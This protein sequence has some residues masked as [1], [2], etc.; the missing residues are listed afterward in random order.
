MNRRAAIIHLAQLMG[1]SI[2]G[3]RLL[4]GAWSAEGTGSGGTGGSA[5][6]ALLD[7][8]GDT[9]LPATDV[10]GAK[11]VNIGSFI[12]MMVRDCY[13]PDQQ[14]AVEAG[15]RELSGRFR[16]RYGHEFVGAP[17][18]ERTDFLNELDAEQRSYARGRNPGQPDHYFRVLKDLT[19]LGYFSSEIGCTQAIRFTEVPGSYNGN[20]PYKQGD[21]VWFS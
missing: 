4:Q 18:S 21:R 20:V 17:S 9:I 8:V 6:L 5:G 12:S 3:P 11:A 7:E 14:A 15:L 19:I 1:S 10:P 13:E 16:A 2:V